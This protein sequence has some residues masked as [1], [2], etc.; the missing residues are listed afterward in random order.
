MSLQNNSN[1][2]VPV[3]WGP[4][5]L[6]NYLSLINAT[7]EDLEVGKPRSTDKQTN[8]HTITSK[9]RNTVSVP[10]KQKRGRPRKPD[11]F[12]DVGIT[13]KRRTQVRLAQRVY[14][15]RKEERITSLSKKVSELEQ[16]L[17]IARGLYLSTHAVVT[18]SGFPL[19]CGN[20]ESSNILYDNL[21]L[22]LSNTD[23]GSS[24]AESTSST[25]P[26]HSIP[27]YASFAP[28]ISNIPR[29]QGI[30]PITMSDKAYAVDFQR[31]QFD[32]TSLHPSMA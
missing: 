12:G 15:T 23:V 3:T 17:L 11:S 9:P 7:I 16:K 13:E 14:R 8:G 26:N 21:Q 1:D 28:I 27:D 22:L 18:T 19:F 6:N 25:Q 29:G 32:Y 4:Y 24:T 30:L 20:N 10:G 31:Q 5:T 2:I